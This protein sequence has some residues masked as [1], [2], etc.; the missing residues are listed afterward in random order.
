MHVLQVQGRGSLH[1]HIILWVHED[2][3]AR[4][5]AEISS[6]IPAVYTGPA[7]PTPPTA[8]LSFFQA[9]E[10]PHLRGLMVEIVNKNQHRC[11]D[12]NM[13]GCRHK[14]PA[15]QYHFPQ[16]LQA[17][18]DPVFD[19]ATNKHCYH[20]R[21]PCDRNTVSACDHACSCIAGLSCQVVLPAT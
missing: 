11:K 19:A 13:P 12:V 5:A 1:A 6:T 14:G 2:D 9:P 18:F 8:Q 4:V 10:C 20:C 7:G 3:R 17:T 16:P 21:R 15:C